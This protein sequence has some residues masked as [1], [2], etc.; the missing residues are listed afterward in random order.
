ME[1]VIRWLNGAKQKNMNGGSESIFDLC[2]VGSHIDKFSSTVM[3]IM[4]SFIKICSF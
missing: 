3:Q 2:D 1:N 4:K